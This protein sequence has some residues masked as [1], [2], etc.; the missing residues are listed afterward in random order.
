MIS[1]KKKLVALI[2]LVLLL[3]CV[4]GGWYYSNAKKVVASGEKESWVK[5]FT[6]GYRVEQYRFYPRIKLA[7]WADDRMRFTY[8]SQWLDIASVVEERWLPKNRAIYLNLNINVYDSD[9]IRVYPA[10]IL[11]DYY[12]GEIY[13]SSGLAMWRAYMSEDIRSEKYKLMTEDEFQQILSRLSE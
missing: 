13:A 5:P 11:Y 9:G 12:R 3:A 1:S 2:A 8:E 7:F 6:Y 10:K 4:V